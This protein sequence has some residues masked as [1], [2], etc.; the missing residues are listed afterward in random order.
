MVPGQYYSS[1]LTRHI[2]VLFLPVKYCR[3]PA[4]GFQGAEQGICITWMSHELSTALSQVKVNLL[5]SSLASKI[6]W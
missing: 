6:M 2:I 3:H 5:H 1:E 4:A